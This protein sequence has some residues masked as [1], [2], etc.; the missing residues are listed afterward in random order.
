VKRLRRQQRSFSCASLRLTGVLPLD[1][2]FLRVAYLAA[3]GL[4]HWRARKQDSLKPRLVAAPRPAPSVVLAVR[5]LS[6]VIGRRTSLACGAGS[7]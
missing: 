6:S 3:M 4:A 7:T 1:G 2:T 5:T